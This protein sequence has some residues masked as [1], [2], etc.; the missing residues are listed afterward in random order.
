MLR[1]STNSSVRTSSFPQNIRFPLSRP[2]SGSSHA[3]PEDYLT[4]E[5]INIDPSLVPGVLKAM[6]D[7]LG[8]PPTVDNLENFG[9]TG[10]IAL[11]AS[12]EREMTNDAKLAGKETI[13]IHFRTNSGAQFTYQAKETETI[14]DV[15]DRNKEELG[16][17]LECACGGIAACSTCHVIIDDETFLNANMSKDIDENELDMLDL[18][19]GMSA[20]SRLGCQ[21]HLTKSCDGMIVTIPD[22][23][24]DLYS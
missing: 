4:S 22:G 16:G 3:S 21:L 9:K 20:T 7:Y 23:V 6:Q 19:W 8:K 24:H 17:L 10:L 15:I 13:T 12:V 2:F 18:A 5:S 11:A 14:K 1:S